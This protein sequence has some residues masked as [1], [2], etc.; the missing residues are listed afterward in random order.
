MSLRVVLSDTWSWPEVRRGGERYLHELGAALAAAG[1]DVSI[2]TTGSRPG[3]ER[4]LDVPV[5]RV[6]RRSPAAGRLGA[7]APEVAFGAQALARLAARRFDVWHA[8]SIPDGAAAAVLSRVRPGLRSAFTDLGFPVARSRRQRPDHRLQS[9]LARHVDSYICFSEAAGAWLGRDYGRAA[10]VVPPGV[11]LQRFRPA[12]QRSP[13]PTIMYSGSLD[14]PRKNVALLLEAV[15]VLRRTLDVEVWL[16][17][18]GDGASLLAAASPAARDAVTFVGPADDA[19]LAER[20]GRAWVLALPSH[21]EAFGMVLVEA[22]ASG[23]PILVSDDGGGPNE[24]LVPGV[25]VACAETVEALAAGLAESLDLAAGPGI[26]EACRARAECY[27]WKTV[28]V[29]M[30]ERL[31]AG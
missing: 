16:C 9:V 27:D 11:D 20:Y 25:G 2:L 7:V 6:R 1:H 13:R 10:D 31:Y 29:P 30:L 17:G 5:H 26:V 19:D 15:A 3:S 28:V 4:I 14:E 8:V 23:T 18:Q 22:L 24:I 21:A 12:A